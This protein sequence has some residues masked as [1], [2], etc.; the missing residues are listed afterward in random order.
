M[1]RAAMIALT[2][3]L[4]GCDDTPKAPDEKAWRQSMAECRAETDKSQDADYILACM[5]AAGFEPLDTEYT[6]DICFTQ[7]VFDTPG[8]WIQK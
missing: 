5:A 2:L 8:C 4:F 1:R 6:P 7:H 3:A